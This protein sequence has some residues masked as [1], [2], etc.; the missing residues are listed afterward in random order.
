MRLRKNSIKVAGCLAAALAVFAMGVNCARYVPAVKR[1]I[2]SAFD[3]NF[4]FDAARLARADGNPPLLHNLGDLLVDNVEKPFLSRVSN[5]N[6]YMYIYCMDL[7][8]FPFLE[9]NDYL[10]NRLVVNKHYS[11]G[12]D[13]YAQNT[14]GGRIRFKTDSPTIDIKITLDKPIFV[15]WA[16]HYSTAGTDVYKIV[17]GERIWLATISPYSENER[18]LNQNITVGNGAEMTDIVIYLPQYAQIDNFEIGL[19]K[20]SHIASPTPYTIEKPIVFYGSS[21]T[22]GSSASRSGLSLPALVANRRD[23][24]F[25]NFGFSGFARGEQSVAEEI[26]RIDMSAFVMEYDHNAD[27]P[28]DLAKTHYA[29]YKTVRDAH[30]KVPIVMLSRISGGYSISES[31]AAERTDIIRQTYER[32]KSDGDN[33]VFLIDGSNL[34]LKN[35]EFYLADGKHPNDLGMTVIAEAIEKCLGALEK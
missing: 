13:Q 11:E 29:F 19:E 21:I 28:E 2:Y 9:E 20:G 5:D 27:T 3:F 10:L 17:D 22:Q 33:N 30:S 32:A 34:F 6:I 16:S 26:T 35:A 1:V 14:A 4:G 7:D 18:N 25:V 24:D 15:P 8:G 31:E 12:V 23:A